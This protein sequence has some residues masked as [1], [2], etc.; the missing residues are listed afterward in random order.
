M[1]DLLQNVNIS[2][3]SILAGITIIATLFE[4]SKIKIDP[5][6]WLFGAIGKLTNKEVVKKLEEQ[7]ESMKEIDAKTDELAE[8]IDRKDAEDARNHILRFG[9]EIKNGIRH[10]EEYFNQIL[11]D[12]TKYEAYCRTHPEFKNEKTA[13][14][15][16]VIR[17]VWQKCVEE[18][19]FL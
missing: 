3:G 12:M 11:D 6:T 19:D 1:M 13:A 8:R 9:D 17:K 10:S 2:G 7:A 18:N 15:E 4:V 14:T 16:K 5:W